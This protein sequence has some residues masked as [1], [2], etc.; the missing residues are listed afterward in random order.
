M[1]SRKL[2]RAPFVPG[3]ISIAKEIFF[4]S[5]IRLCFKFKTNNG[6]TGWSATKNEW[7]ES[8]SA[9]RQNG[10]DAIYFIQEFENGC[11]FFA[12]FVIGG[13]LLFWTATRGWRM[14]RVQHQ[15]DHPT[16]NADVEFSV[17]TFRHN[18]TVGG[19]QDRQIGTDVY[20]VV[21]FL[22]SGKWIASNAKMHVLK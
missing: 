18:R 8:G 14:G 6:Q 11:F 22:L 19:T 9:K 17:R 12:R 15:R 3:C 7:K 5:F 21:F 20:A 2:M 4:R 13:P 10:L 1:N 16:L